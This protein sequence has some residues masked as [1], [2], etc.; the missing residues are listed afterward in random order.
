[1]PT[2]KLTHL[3]RSYAK[4][5]VDRAPDGFILTLEKDK[6]KR[7]LNQ[8]RTA[9]MWVGEIKEFFE[10]QGKSYTTEQIRVW[11]NDLFLT[12]DVKEVEGR[13]IEIPVSWAD[14]EKAKFATFMNA[15][16]QY[17]ANDL[18]LLLTIPHMP[19]EP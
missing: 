2:I 19:E 6:N 13:M 15:I 5:Q 14:M 16:D 8:L 4:A 7:S 11:L 17:C 12:P 10:A 3:N 9:F 18:G 1:M